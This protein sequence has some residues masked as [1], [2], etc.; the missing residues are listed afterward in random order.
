MISGL[1]EEIAGMAYHQLEQR[2]MLP[3]TDVALEDSAEILLSHGEHPITKTSDG[4]AVQNRNEAYSALR[5]IADYLVVD[6]P[7]SPAPYLIYKAIEWGRMNTGQLYNELFI[8]HQGQLNIFEMLGIEPSEK[9]AETGST[10][11]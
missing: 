2:G 9:Q 8:E 4:D 11:A 7:H 5:S 3:E 6:D 10:S 1:L